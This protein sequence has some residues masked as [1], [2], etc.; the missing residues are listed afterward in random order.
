MKS[1]KNK[2]LEEDLVDDLLNDD[3]GAFDDLPAPPGFDDESD[4]PTSTIPIAVVPISEEDLKATP[5]SELPE[6]KNR[7]ESEDTIRISESKVIPT[8]FSNYWGKAKSAL[9]TKPEAK[10]AVGGKFASRA[11]GSVAG[12]STEAA[13]IQSEN[14][15]IAQ[16]KIFELEE[17]IE[18]LRGENE[19]LAAAGETIRRRSDELQAENDFKSQK[20]GDIKERLDSEKDILEASLMARERE[21]REMKSKVEEYEIRLQSN[22]QKIRVRERELENRLELVKMESTALVRSKD[23]MILELK[24]QLDQL[25]AELE[26]FRA[27]GH[28]LN[29]QIGEKQ[30]TL[31]RTVKALRLAL[32]LLEGQTDNPEILKKAK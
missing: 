15:R 9:N 28:E 3:T 7:P 1:K 16:Q 22:L 32:S 25:S 20:I 17:E 19:Q 12:S 18:R 23:E 5:V 4:S 2:T 24:R 10:T 26:N 13:L 6:K 14:L 30:E 21:L 29:R 11:L 31:R 27:K 8:D